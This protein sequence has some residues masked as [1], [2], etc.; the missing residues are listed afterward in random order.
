MALV[1]YAVGLALIWVLAWG[2]PSPANVLGGLAVAAVLLAIAPD[3]WSQLRRARPRIRPVAIARFLGFVLVEVVQ[4]NVVI[5][6]E[7]LSRES[8]ITTGVVAVPLP[9][10]SD[11][12]LTL[13]TNVMAVTPGTM[14]IEVTRHPTVIY[15]HVLL[16]GDVDAVRRDVQHLAALAYRAFGSD[17]AIAAIDEL[18]RASREAAS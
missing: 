18:A 6:R 10:C 3:S 8:N 13:V 1:A 7:V 11:G 14:P 2:T 16:L 17:H 15:V 9:E 5:T 4:A 12:L